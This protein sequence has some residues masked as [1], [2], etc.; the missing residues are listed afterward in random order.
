MWSKTLATGSSKAASST[1]TFAHGQLE[2]RDLLRAQ[3]RP[4]LLLGRH[5][6]CDVVAAPDEIEERGRELERA[7]IR[8][9]AQERRHDGRRLVRGRLLLVLA[10]VAGAALASEQE[11]DDEHHGER[12]REGEGRERQ[13]RPA[14]V[15][16]RVRELLAILV[17]VLGTLRLLGD[18]L[19]EPVAFDDAGSPR[20]GEQP[21]G[22]HRPHLHELAGRDVGGSQR[23]PRARPLDDAV[24]PLGSAP[25]AVP[26]ARER[27]RPRQHH[28]R[29]EVIDG[30]GPVISP[31]LEVDV[32]DVVVGDRE[33]AE[34]VGDRESA[35]AAVCAVV[36]DDPH[37]VV[38]LLHAEDVRLVEA[39]Q[40][41]VASGP[42]ASAALAHLHEVDVL[43][44][45]HGNVPVRAAERSR[46]RERDVLP[47]E[48]GA[49][50]RD[51][52]LND[53]LRQ[54]VRLRLRGARDH[55]DEGRD[56]ADDV[57][58]SC[59]DQGKLT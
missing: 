37:L 48:Q 31:D 30:H 36:P 24:H 40:L 4:G 15:V 17:V 10:V 13:H 43:A 50:G 51:L 53:R 44:V 23:R 3:A 54:R 19:R 21:P 58:A 25:D 42:V 34:A 39:P 9:L 22:E 20:R 33:P 1:S 18:D 27:D 41:G 49:V 16:S 28:L 14:E 35:D 45:A 56:D 32:D 26:R 12:R 55:E 5:R 2:V 38:A 52:R 8:A 6:L 7:G 59:S 11:P 47:H 57:R 29:A 46:V